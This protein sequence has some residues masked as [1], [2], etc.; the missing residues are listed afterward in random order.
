[1]TQP[2]PT[3]VVIAGGGTAGWIA[4]AAIQRQL[5][6][7]VQVTL[8]ESEAIGTVGVGEATIPTA[9]SFHE[10]LRIDEAE[11]MRAT[12]ATFK[13][14]IQFEDWGAV[15]DSYLHSF[16]T[17]P[18]K[19]WVA[20]FQHF[21]LEAQARGLAGPVGAYCLEHE[22]ALAGKFAREGQAATNYAYHLDAGRY[23]AFLRRIA[24]AEGA[25]RTEGRIASVERD[26][27]SGDV[28]A[29][30]LES[31]ERVAG[32]LFID[33]TGFRALLIEG[34][35]QAGFEDWSH[36]LPMD[37]AFAMQT[38]LTAD[39]VP[40]TRAIAHEAGW[41]W[42]IPLQ[43]RM[44]NGCVFSSRF[45]EA[46]AARDLL[47]SSVEG[48][49]LTE[50]RLVRFATGKRRRVWQNN[51]VALGLSS[52]FVEPLESTSIHLFMAGVT[53]LIQQFPFGPIGEAQR[54]RYNRMADNEIDRVR[55]FVILHYKLNQREDSP[56]WRHVAA[57]D[58]PDTLA[59]RITLFA[60]QA[61]AWQAADDLFRVESWAQVL[62]GQNCRPSSWHRLAGLVSDEKL[63]A[64]LTGLRDNVAARVAAM[65]RH[66]EVIA[67][68]CAAPKD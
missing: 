19:T 47:Q 16:G 9:R 20:E 28:A 3:R 39:P 34:E 31:G 15:G 45:M 58:V 60:E 36:W 29:L 32:D 67:A 26:G 10:L 13:L 52:G 24:E 27:Q 7:L 4:A 8:V 55:D 65:P 1:M 38:R 50:P 68:Y 23:A 5:G 61:E 44:G 12:G 17:V 66:S 43:H 51:V 22:A 37:G 21:W 35:L 57:M 40:Y 6:R 42:R 2:A 46:D 63:R 56:L 53:R 49:P 62:L 18:L 59:E 33:C 41:Q 64:T 14:G 48:E 54:A 11:F 30:L 25:V